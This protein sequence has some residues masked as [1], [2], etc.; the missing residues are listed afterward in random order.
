M[1]QSN[2]QTVLYLHC[3]TQQVCEQL[4]PCQVAAAAQLKQFEQKQ[5]V[6]V[7]AVCH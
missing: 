5:L 6:L 7:F 1:G 2:V 3:H 4:T